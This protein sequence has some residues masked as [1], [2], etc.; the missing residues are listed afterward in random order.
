MP[1]GGL[2]PPRLAATNFESAVSTS[3][4]HP[5][6]CQALPPACRILLKARMTRLQFL[7]CR[8]GLTA[9]RLDVLPRAKHV[10]EFSWRQRLHCAATSTLHGWHSSIGTRR[11]VSYA[12]LLTFRPRPTQPLAATAS[13]RPR[14]MLQDSPSSTAAKKTNGAQRGTRTPTPCG[15][16]PSTLRVYQF[17][18]LGIVHV[19]DCSTTNACIIAQ[20]KDCAT[21]IW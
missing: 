16:T 15:T 3:S 12:H 7:Y 4:I 10:G 1:R 6:R 17:H 19:D 8:A 2:E 14:H 21:P 9:R 11:P 13:S 20:N 5:G 18:H